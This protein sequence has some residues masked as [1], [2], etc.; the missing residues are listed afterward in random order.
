MT[1][2]FRTTPRRTPPTLIVVHE[3]GGAG[4]VPQLVSK[5]QGD[6]NGVHYIVARDGKLFEL[7]DPETEVVAHISTWNPRAIGVELPNPVGASTATGKALAR[8][9]EQQGAPGQIIEHGRFASGLGAQTAFYNP[10]PQ[11]EAFYQLLRQ[12]LRRFSTVPTRIGPLQPGGFLFGALPEEVWAAGGVFPHGAWAGDGHFDGFFP[13]LYAVARIAGLGPE[14]AWA[15]SIEATEAA[16][17]RKAFDVTAYLGRP[18]PTTLPAQR[19]QSLVAAS[20]ADVERLLP[21]LPGGLPRARPLAEAPTTALSYHPYAPASVA[22]V[23]TTQAGRL[24]DFD[25]G[26]WV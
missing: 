4:E 14:P 11:C 7:A 17:P 20:R 21:P 3:S 18:I 9:L 16:S 22:T 13:V 26:E 12:L 10:L 5:L 23:A 24:Y 19:A 15:K 6:G 2:V 8:R 1:G 25:T